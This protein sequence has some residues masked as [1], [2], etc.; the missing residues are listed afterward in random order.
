MLRLYD[1]FLLEFFYHG[2]HNL[3]T[4]SSD[5]DV[6]SL[7]VNPS[8]PLFYE[9]PSINEVKTPQ[10][11]E[12]FQPEM[13]VMSGLRCLEFGFAFDK[14]ILQTLKAPHHSSIC[15]QNHSNTQ[16]LLPPLELHDP[17]AHASEESYIAS[18]RA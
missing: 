5:Q 2:C 4:L 13:M 7:I 1:S 18:T 17:I 9:D 6:D 15:T 14:E 10:I 8:R 11:I 12:A 3:F 16:I